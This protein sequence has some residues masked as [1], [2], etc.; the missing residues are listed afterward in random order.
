M[1]VQISRAPVAPYL[2][3]GRQRGFVRFALICGTNESKKEAGL[4]HLLKFCV[5]QRETA[6]TCTF[7]SIKLSRPS[8]VASFDESC[9]EYNASSSQRV[10][11]FLLFLCSMPNSA[12]LYCGGTIIVPTPPPSKKKVTSTVLLCHGACSVFLFFTPLN[13]FMICRELLKI[14]N[15]TLMN[16][17]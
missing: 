6:R 5:R 9:I 12:D 2:S 11:F 14:K 3:V 17:C 4:C 13:V 7:F 15:K 16:L 8:S 1:R 10:S